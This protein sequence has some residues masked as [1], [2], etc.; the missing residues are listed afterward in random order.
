MVTVF[1]IFSDRR[2]IRPLKGTEA[3]PLTIILGF[4]TNSQ[5][6][7]TSIR[8]DEHPCHLHKGVFPGKIRSLV[9]PTQYFYTLL[10]K[11]NCSISS[12][13]A[14][15]PGAFIGHFFTSPSPQWVIC[16]RKK[17]SPGAGHCQKQL[18][19]SDFKRVI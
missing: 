11:T 13:P 8:Y 2:P 7:L 18:G 16:Q 12:K 9:H 6:F 3:T 1:V 15:P 17:V 10:N 14:H 19:L 4:S 5:I